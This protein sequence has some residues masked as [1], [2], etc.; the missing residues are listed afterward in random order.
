MVT[1]GNSDAY[2]SFDLGY[3]SGD[4][5]TRATFAIGPSGTFVNITGGADGL[6]KIYEN[7][8]IICYAEFLEVGQFIVGGKV[9]A[10]KKEATLYQNYL[11]TKSSWPFINRKFQPKPIITIPYIYRPTTKLSSRQAY[12][13]KRKKWV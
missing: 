6:L 11:D 2:I 3:M 12:Q 1:C 10:N 9:F 4:S 7:G 13:N 8:K 5:I